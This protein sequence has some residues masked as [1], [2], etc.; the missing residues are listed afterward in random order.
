M[1][2]LL[3]WSVFLTVDLNFYFSKSKYGGECNPTLKNEKPYQEIKER[4]KLDQLPSNSLAL[5]VS[6]FVGFIGLTGVIGLKQQGNDTLHLIPNQGHCVVQLE[7]DNALD[8]VPLLDVNFLCK[9]S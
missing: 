1:T 4:T 8:I 9:L 3:L 5:S 6:W 2:F 7:V